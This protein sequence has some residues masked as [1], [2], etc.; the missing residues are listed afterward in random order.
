MPNVIYFN[1]FQILSY[2][3]QTAT[4]TATAT[5]TTTKTNRKS[6]KFRNCFRTRPLAWFLMKE[7]LR[8]LGL[9]LKLLTLIKNLS[10]PVFDLSLQ[11]LKDLKELV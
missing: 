7:A 1:I 11:K 6:S 9:K 10:D 2:K 8:Q 3:V 5:T 4:T